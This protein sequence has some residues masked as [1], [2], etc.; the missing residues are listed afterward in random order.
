MADAAATA[1]GNLVKNK[2]DIKWA[3]ERG[4][5]IEGVRGIVIILGEHFGVVGEVELV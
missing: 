4:I 3:L 5:K 1:I 2:S